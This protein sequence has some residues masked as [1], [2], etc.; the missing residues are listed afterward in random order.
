MKT[1]S[2]FQSILFCLLLLNFSGC[3]DHDI[4]PPASDSCKLTVIDRGNGNKHTYSYD[5]QGRITTMTRAFDGTGAGNTTEYVYALTYDGDGRLVKSD[6]THNDKPDGTEIYTYT[7]GRIS[8]VDFTNADGSREVYSIKYNAAGQIIEFAYDSGDPDED[9]KDLFEYNAD[10]VTTKHSTVDTE[11]N[12]LYESRFKPVGKVTSPEQLLAKHGLPYDL[13]TGF[14]WSVA[15]GD[16]GTTSEYFEA[17]NTGKLVSSGSDKTTS[18]KTNAK[19]YL[20]EDSYVDD[21]KKT[22]TRKFILEDCN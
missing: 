21:T 13:L 8:K 22:V 9:G 20:I 10:G 12:V 1:R 2:L 6:I 14:S 11:G 16:V 19:G 15:E 3:T 5:A 17:D 18:A 4:N 7:N